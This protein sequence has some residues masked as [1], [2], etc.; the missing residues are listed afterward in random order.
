MALRSRIAYAAKHMAS[1]SHIECAARHMATRSRIACAARHMA[2]HSHIACAARHM[3]TR[4]RI[5]CAA[6]AHGDAFPHCMRGQAHGAPPRVAGRFPHPYKPRKE[7]IPMVRFANDADLARINELRRQVN[8]LHVQGRPDM[9]M[10]GFGAQIQAHAAGLLH[11]DDHA[12]LVA[13]RDGVICGM[14]CVDYVDKPE[15][16]VQPCASI[17]P[18]AGAGRRCGSAPAGRGAGAGRVHARRRTRARLWRAS[19]W[20]CGRSCGRGGVL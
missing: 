19:S 7:L 6:L 14:A 13:E 10:P 3:A 18:C 11:A 20:T 2:T 8:E 1:R 12:I 16:A 9:F 5:A 17:L 15:T 4:S